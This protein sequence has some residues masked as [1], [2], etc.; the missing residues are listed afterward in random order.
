MKTLALIAA[1]AAIATTMSASAYAYDREARIDI[2]RDQQAYR[3]RH[4]RH[5]GELTLL[6]K[7]RLQGEQRRIAGMERAA[8]RDGYI[9]RREANR[10][11]AQQDKASYD[12]YRDSHNGRKAWW[13]N[14]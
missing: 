12:I 8:L 7:W 1:T 2:R 9:S 11:S 4:D 14:W 3:I 5:T 13:R 10:I 6:E